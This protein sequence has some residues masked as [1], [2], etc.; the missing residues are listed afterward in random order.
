MTKKPRQEDKEPKRNK[1]ING[2]LQIVEA[3]PLP[4]EAAIQ[5]LQRLHDERQED[6]A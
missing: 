4:S 2:I 6:P 3:K 1:A 5:T